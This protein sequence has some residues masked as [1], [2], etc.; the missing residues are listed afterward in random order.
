MMMTLSRCCLTL[1]ALLAAASLH[2][3][4]TPQPAASQ[5]KPVDLTKPVS[6]VKK[7]AAPAPAAPAKPT[8]A[9]LD[10]VHTV[11]MMTLVYGGEAYEVMFELFDKAAP[12][13]VQ[14]FRENASKGVYNKVAVHRAVNDYLVQTGDPVSKDQDTRDSWG[15]TE[16]Y[17]IPAEIKLPHSV[18]AVAM[19]RRSDKV[20]PQRK[21]DGTQFYF[22][23]GN[24]SAL[25][26]QY[27]VFG[28]VVSGFDALKRLSKIATDSNDCPLERV[29]IRDLKVFDQ[30]G[31]IVTM[32]GK[33]KG[34][35]TTKPEAAMTPM[36]KVIH[37]IW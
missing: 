20:N 6:A 7:K 37:R 19:A 22:V 36:E 17:T 11:A 32:V 31:P 34:R 33:G 27:T 4:S 28:K 3:Q 21:S 23:V 25:D 24:M 18:G 30:K 13:T 2:A 15:L 12:K 16:E 14:N 8:Q 10:E 1:T 26:G 29:E 5:P 35:R 9:Q